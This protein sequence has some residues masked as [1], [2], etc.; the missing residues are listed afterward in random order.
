MRTNPFC[1]PAA[2]S[3]LA[4]EPVRQIPQLLEDL[5]K[6]A[7][8]VP[9]LYDTLPWLKGMDV[10]VLVIERV[11]SL[12]NQDEPLAEQEATLMTFFAQVTQPVAEMIKILYASPLFRRVSTVEEIMRRM[13]QSVGIPALPYD[14]VA[15]V[16]CSFWRSRTSSEAPIQRQETTWSLGWQQT[17]VQVRTAQGTQAPC[18]LLVNDETTGKILAFR[19]TQGPPGKADILFTLVDAL[20]FSTRDP[21]HLRPPAHLAV[22]GPV[23]P[24]IVRAGKSWKIEVE[25]VEPQVSPFVAQWERE[26]VNRVLDPIQ[27]LRIFDR[28]CERAFGFAPFLAKQR[29]ARLI[30]WSMDR[31]HDPTRTLPDLQEVLPAY[32]ASVGSDGTLV[33]QGWHYRDR[34]VDVLRYWPGEAVTIRPSPLS[35]AV[36]W[37]YWGQDILCCALAEELCHKDGKCRPYWFPYPRLGE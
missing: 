18:L 25:E 35:E 12:F 11:S 15:G 2:P 21:W 27:Y 20:V 23:L 14:V 4:Q 7:E 6:V 22:R 16:C 30:G 26:L 1:Q 9:A 13:A 37:V 32:E 10:M 3:W 33:W 29:A 28:A 8:Y 24:E 19:S 5:L 17:A 34:E 36:I 31:Y